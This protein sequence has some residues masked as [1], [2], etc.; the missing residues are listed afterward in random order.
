MIEQP[1][2]EFVSLGATDVRITPLGLG[3]WQWGDRFVWGYGQGYGEQDVREAFSASLAGGV[4]FFDTAEAYGNGRSEKLLGQFVRASSSQAIIATKFFPYPWR[5]RRVSLV[6]AL[7]RSLSRLSMKQVDLYQIHWPF[8][9]IPIET[10]IA[11]LADAVEAGLTRAVGVSN[12]NLAQTRRAYDTLARRG[13][14][15]ASNQVEYSLL[16]RT[17]ERDGLLQFC[18]DKNITLIAYSPIAKGILTGKYT[19]Q[20][21]PP[22]IRGRTYNRN[23]LTRVQPLIELLK[24]IGE[25]HGKS[26]S[27]VALNWVICKGAVAIPRRRIYDK[28]AR[29]RARWAGD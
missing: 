18:R 21:T 20:H 9:P 3:A 24:K 1:N 2:V 6:S 8:P 28:R 7:R 14:P 27:Q 23:Y 25:M 12:Y 15:L 13:I 5:W 11:G 29:T 19:P 17:P 26:L 22:G 10:W 4:N 16:R